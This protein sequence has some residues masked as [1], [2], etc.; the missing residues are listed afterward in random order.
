MI[1]QE[2]KYRYTW[3]S[4]F[5]VDAD[6]V[7]YWKYGSHKAQFTV[8][9]HEGT[10]H[11]SDLFDAEYYENIM[12]ELTLFMEGFVTDFDNGVYV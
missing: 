7:I 12:K 6:V 1:I 9:T 4:T 5:E 8:D 11:E 2:L 3:G 10:R